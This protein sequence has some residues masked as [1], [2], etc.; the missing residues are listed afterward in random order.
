M[1]LRAGRDPGLEMLSPSSGV[2]GTLNHN[3]LL[4][5]N[6]WNHDIFLENSILNDNILFEDDILNHNILLEDTFNR[7]VSRKRYTK[8]CRL[9]ENVH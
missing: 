6:I 9:T 7:T 5:S 3:V 2:R 1:W 8:P 4:E